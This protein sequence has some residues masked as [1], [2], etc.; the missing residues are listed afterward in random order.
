MLILQHSRKKP[1][2][3]CVSLRVCR[4]SRVFF[5]GKFFDFRVSQIVQGSSVGFSSFFL[6]L[7][8]HFHWFSPSHSAI[9]Q[10]HSLDQLIPW[11]VSV[12]SPETV[13]N[14]WSISEHSFS[15]RQNTTGN[16]PRWILEIHQDS[17]WCS[18]LYCVSARSFELLKICRRSFWKSA[19]DSENLP[20]NL[21]WFRVPLDYVT[22]HTVLCCMMHPSKA[23]CRFWPQISNRIR[24]GSEPIIAKETWTLLGATHIS[25]KM[26]VFN[27]SDHVFMEFQLYRPPF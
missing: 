4:F 10:N 14:L 6:L 2:L 26:T 11:L 3:S 25:L 13:T 18:P 17:L 5:W 12:S 24:N 27:H 21:I 7:A 16:P 1:Q 9:K 19:T 20:L 15:F 8:S 23:E 22:H